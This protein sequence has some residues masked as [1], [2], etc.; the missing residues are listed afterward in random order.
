MVEVLGAPKIF[1]FFFSFAE[2]IYSIMY[3]NKYKN[4]QSRRQMSSLLDIQI[5][6]QVFNKNSLTKPCINISNNS[7]VYSTP[8]QYHKPFFYILG[9]N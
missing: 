7:T 1:F 2:R 8:S 6:F 9:Y 5:H 4:L 3:K